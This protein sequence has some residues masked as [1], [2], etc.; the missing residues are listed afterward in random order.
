MILSW[1][2]PVCWSALT[3]LALNCDW[4]MA[5]AIQNFK[6]NKMW[7]PTPDLYPD[8]LFVRPL[9]RHNLLTWEHCCTRRKPVPSSFVELVKNQLYSNS[10]VQVPFSLHDLAYFTTNGLWVK[11]PNRIR[12]HSGAEI[13]LIF[14][15][16]SISPSIG[17]SALSSVQVFLCVFSLP[18]TSFHYFKVALKV[19]A[20]AINWS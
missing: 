4:R 6:K 18:T 3:W 1:P 17:N 8:L 14:F 19:A 7:M 12:G 11:V 20:A 5:T 13:S 2:L 9:C 15:L 16:T 10:N